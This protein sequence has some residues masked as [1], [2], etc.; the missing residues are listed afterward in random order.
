MAGSAVG[1]IIR[2]ALL[3]PAAALAGL[4]A[5][6]EGV[7]DRFPDFGMPGILDDLGDGGAPRGGGR[8]GGGRSQASVTLAFDS[9]VFNLSP[10]SP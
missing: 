9:T 4:G 10:P 3:Y 5:A 7:K 2:R 8:E 6:A 1:V